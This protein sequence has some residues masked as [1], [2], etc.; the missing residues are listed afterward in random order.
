MREELGGT[1]AVEVDIAGEGGRGGSG[2]EGVTR[3]GSRGG[4]RGRGR[5]EDAVRA[6]E[7][8]IRLW[9]VNSRWPGGDLRL[10]S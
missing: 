9:R 1:A 5:L 7:V 3:R 2:I 10:W 6:A 8:E 4:C